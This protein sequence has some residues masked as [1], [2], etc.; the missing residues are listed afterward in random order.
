VAGALF[1][2]AGEAV[3]S[4]TAPP[5]GVTQAAM[6]RSATSRA[7][8]LVPIKAPAILTPDLGMTAF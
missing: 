4:P 6:D 1:R 2:T 3:L 8:D 7:V 5:A